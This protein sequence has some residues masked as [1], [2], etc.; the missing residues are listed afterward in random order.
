MKKLSLIATAFFFHLFAAFAQQPDSGA[1]KPRALKIEEV[2]F[3]SSYYIQ[4]G[5][6]S[7]VTGGRGTEKLTDFA[8]DLGIILL[9]TNKHG[10]RFNWGVDVGI[11]HYTSASSD[12]IDPNTVSG[13]SS[14][15]TRIY[16]SVAWSTFGKKGTT[17]GIDASY[18][19]EYDYKS[20]G[21][22]LTYGKAFRN[23]S[24]ELAVHLQSYFDHWSVI[25]PAEL[26]GSTTF[27]GYLSDNRAPRN[28]Y[29]A[30]LVFSQI[31]NRRLQVAA[32]L[33]FI[34]QQG[35]LA[36]NY[37]RV[38]FNDGTESIEYLP[39]KRSKIPI[40][41][42]AN[43]FINDRFIVRSWYRY[44]MDDWGIRAHT[45]NL[46]LPVKITAFFSVNGF[47]RFYTQTAAD[48]FAPYRSHTTAENYYTSDYDLSALSS[49]FIGAGIRLVPERG[50]LKIKHFNTLELRFGHYI[51]TTGL[52]SN[53]ISLN[54]GFR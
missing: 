47:Y 8:N 27:T 18:S 34:Y 16:P 29:S 12:N 48:Y 3:V 40:G 45:V 21:M 1:Y 44:Y 4:D 37:Q 6:N 52:T 17:I 36:T 28:S 13:P 20:V 11:D 9:K 15:D 49:H 30:S 38:Y 25:Y 14:G 43:V 53:I 42:R 35:L 22:G 7:A 24:S 50:I 2:N 32:L 39:G 23:K 10:R 41:L 33:D 5:N 31:I 19:T 51:R 26:R 46:E 54:A